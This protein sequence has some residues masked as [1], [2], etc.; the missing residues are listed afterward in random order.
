[1]SNSMPCTACGKKPQSRMRRWT[2]AVALYVQLFYG[3]PYEWDTCPKCR[4][5][6]KVR[7]AGRDGPIVPS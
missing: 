7:I 1:M 4:S 6:G 2:A 5:R 3:I